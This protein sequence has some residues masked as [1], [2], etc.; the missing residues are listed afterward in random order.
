M[1]RSGMTSSPMGLGAVKYQ[2]TR[3]RLECK[4]LTN[5]NEMNGLPTKVW[6]F[7]NDP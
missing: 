7:F 2:L 3:D 6:S 5:V 1:N 4:V